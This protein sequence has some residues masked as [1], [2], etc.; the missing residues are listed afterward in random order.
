MVDLDLPIWDSP[1]RTGSDLP[2]E[3]N[4]L[5]QGLMPTKQRSSMKVHETRIYT[6]CLFR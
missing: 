2:T 6:G 1:E 4:G 5:K 3:S